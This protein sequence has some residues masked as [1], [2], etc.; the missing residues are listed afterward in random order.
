MAVITQMS[1]AHFY[2]KNIIFNSKA[3]YMYNVGEIGSAPFVL[4]AEDS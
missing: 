1:F 4:T 3:D 2:Q